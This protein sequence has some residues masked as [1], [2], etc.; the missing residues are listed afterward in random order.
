MYFCTSKLHNWLRLFLW[1]VFFIVISQLLLLQCYVAKQNKEK[2]N[3][4]Q[5]RD[6]CF[7]HECS[8][9][10]WFDW[11]HLGLTDLSW[12]SLDAV[13]SW[14]WS[15]SWVLMR[16]SAT[17]GMA[18]HGGLQ[19]SLTGEASRILYAPKALA[20]NGHSLFTIICILSTKENHMA[21]F[22][23]SGQR[24]S[25]C[26]FWCKAPLNHMA[27]VWTYNSNQTEGMKNWG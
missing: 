8:G 5:H 10:L 25:L 22:S 14:V 26:L 17:Q 4:L 11:T 2:T 18:F 19:N 21:M 6:L 7:T 24:N 23:I 1:A 9:W 3:G 20:Q 16:P 15:S 27:K 13:F 12:T